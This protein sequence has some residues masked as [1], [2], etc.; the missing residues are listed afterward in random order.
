[1]SATS[2]DLQPLTLI[3]TEMISRTAKT[4]LNQQ[5][6]AITGDTIAYTTALVGFLNLL[7]GNSEE[8]MKFWKIR[9]PIELQLKFGWYGPIFSEKE[10]RAGYDFRPY[11][12][13][14][15]LLLSLQV[16]SKRM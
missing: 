7:L 1:M 10:S 11:V 14:A 9:I 13:R 16:H 3:L 2:D 5:L 6:R 4:L 12:L 8:S 15:D